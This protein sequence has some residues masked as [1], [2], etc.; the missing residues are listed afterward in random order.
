[1]TP[2]TQAIQTVLLAHNGL[3]ALLANSDSPTTYRIYALV[4]P[5]GCDK[6][7]LVRERLSQVREATMAES[8]GYGVDNQRCRFSIYAATLIE[9]MAVEEQLRLALE[10]GKTSTF[11]AVQVFSN[12]TF[13]DDTHLYRVIV[14]YSI[15]YRHTS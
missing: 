4:A 15:W 1:M 6:P 10:S 3:K 9:C 5:Q 13:E 14:D 8:G 2:T 7:F 11:S 12:E